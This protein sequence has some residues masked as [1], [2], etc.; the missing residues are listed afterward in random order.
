[1]DL[2]TKEQFKWKFYRLVLMLNLIILIV[3]IA[4]IALFR[5]PEGYRIPAFLLLV[6]SAVVAT[7]YVRSQYQST[8][9]WLENQE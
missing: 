7:V 6:I 4:I 8:R 1:M 2:A 3:A 9:K 5:A